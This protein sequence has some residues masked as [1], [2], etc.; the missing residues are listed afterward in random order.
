MPLHCC[1]H[2]SPRVFIRLG[3]EGFV[4]SGGVGSTSGAGRIPAGAW[5]GHHRPRRAD[6][7]GLHSRPT[8]LSSP[9]LSWCSCWPFGRRACLAARGRKW[10]SI[11]AETTPRASDC[12]PEVAAARQS[13]DGDRRDRPLVHPGDRQRFL[14]VPD[15]RLVVHPS[16]IIA[17][18]VMFLAG[19]GGMVSLMQMTVAGVAGYS[20]AMFGVST[21]PGVNIG[22]PGGLRRHR[23][24]RGHGLRNAR[25]RARGAHR[26]HLHDRD[27]SRDRC[28]VLLSRQRELRDFQRPHR[29][30]RHRLAATFRKFAP[31]F[32]DP[33]SII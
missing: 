19:Y 25:R 24:R 15:F 4:A 17:L 32:A 12:P 13:A 23:A 29:H 30:Q 6:G 21:S 1:A 2:S 14:A 3:Q 8:R 16:G 11:G 33:P 7:F 20:C 27:H 5:R 9:F 18:S 28:G 22:W 26:R 31:A 10:P